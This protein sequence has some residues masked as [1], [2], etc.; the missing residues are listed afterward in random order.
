MSQIKNMSI[1]V[2]QLK[3]VGA[4]TAEQLARLDIYTVD[5]LLFHLPMR[6]EDRTQVVPIRFLQTGQLGL[7]E[8]RIESVEVKQGK[9]RILSCRLSDATGIVALRFFHFYPNQVKKLQ[10]RPLLRCFGEVKEGYQCLEMVHPTYEL[11]EEV[12]ESELLKD[13]LTPIYPSVSNFN[14]TQWHSVMKQALLIELPELLPEKLLLHLKLPNLNQALKIVHQ[15]LPSERLTEIDPSTHPARRRIAFEELL[16]QHLSLRALHQHS[17]QHTAPIFEPENDLVQRFM[18]QLSFDLTKAQQKVIDEMTTN[19]HQAKPMQRLLQG[20]VGSGKTVVA[21]LIALQAIAAGYQV[22]IM[23]PTELL[24]EQ[25]KNTFAEWFEPLGLKVTWLTGSLT[26]KKRRNALEDLILGITHIAVGTHALFQDDVKFDKLGLVIIDE[27][28]RFGVH[29]RLALRDKGKQGDMYPHQLIMTAT[30]IPRTLAM[31]AYADL[32]VSVID[33]LPPGRTPVQTAVV[34]DAKRDHVIQRVHASCKQGK[35]A[36]WVCPLIEESESLQLQA[37]E[38]TAQHLTERLSDLKVG[39]V[40]GRMSSKDKELVMQQFKNAELDLL[41]ATTVI[42]VG[43]NVP[44]ASVMVIENAERLGLAQL[45]QL[46]GRVGRGAVESYC[47][48]LYQAPLSKIAQE[49]LGTIRDST[50]GF[51]IA[52][53]DLEIRGPGEV[54]GTRQTGV[55]NLKVA[56]L[57]KDKGLFAEIPQAGQWMLEHY[58]EQCEQLIQRWIKKGFRYGVV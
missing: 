7:I 17:Q 24:A 46:R 28:H 9:K 58:P 38:D 26:Q 55:L 1:P 51:F 43:V 20:D 25:H 14:Q 12:Q 54:L 34:S 29:Q 2:T 49:R 57:E 19:L 27:Q 50:D 36:Y 6:Y 44:N 47:L 33:E 42:E 5:D 39:L 11:I 23:A 56:D 53:K 35:Q 16:A 32:D 3:G 15:P 45:H 31:T 30:P 48:L 13:H 37:A 40:H 10:Q 41:V 4:R 8:G 21:A 52:Q 18:Q 22:A